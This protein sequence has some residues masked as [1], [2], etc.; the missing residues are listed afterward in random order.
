M[1]QTY[2]LT[3]ER[4]SGGKVPNQ[5]CLRHFPNRDAGKFGKAT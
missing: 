3:R 1:I 4:L 5:L 2:T